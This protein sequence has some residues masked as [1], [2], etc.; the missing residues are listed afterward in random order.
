MAGYVV[1]HATVTYQ[2]K[3][4]PVVVPYRVMVV[5]ASPGPSG[6]GPTVIGFV[7]ISIAQR[8]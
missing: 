6:Q 7:H 1:A 4:K 3:G 2:V 5:T 8:R